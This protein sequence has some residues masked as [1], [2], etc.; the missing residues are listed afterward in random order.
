MYDGIAPHG[1]G[2]ERGQPNPLINGRTCKHVLKG[3]DCPLSSP[4]SIPDPC[5]Y[6]TVRTETENTVFWRSHGVPLVAHLRGIDSRV[7]VRI[8][9]QALHCANSFTLGALYDS[10]A[11]HPPNSEAPFRPFAS[12]TRPPLPAS[13]PHSRA[14]PISVNAR[15]P[16]GPSQRAPL[17]RLS[18]SGQPRTADHPS[19]ADTKLSRWVPIYIVGYI[20][21]A[22]PCRTLQAWM[23]ISRAVASEGVPPGLQ[24]HRGGGGE[25]GVRLSSWLPASRNRDRPHLDFNPARRR[26]GRAHCTPAAECVPK[27]V[28][29][30]LL[31]PALAAL[32]IVA[33]VGIGSSSA[34][35]VAT[36]WPG[37]LA[38]VAQMAFRAGGS[39][40]RCPPRQ[41]SNHQCQ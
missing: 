6:F 32:Q 18:G 29:F 7:D 3:L 21:Q 22:E 10:H 23:Q 20:S 1:H 33:Y 12:G 34:A 14:Q 16:S 15:Q 39:G 25:T 35:P 5:I 40:R 11:P 36:C 37:T 41:P 8:D 13:N 9:S 27:R 24:A 26:Q 19:L 17:L 2:Q 30:P 4:G 38:P 28:G 31:R